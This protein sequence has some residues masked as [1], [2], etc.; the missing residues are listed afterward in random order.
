MSTRSTV[1]SGRPVRGD[2]IRASAVLAGAIV[3]IIIGGL[4]GS[5][6]FGLS[7]GQVAQDDPTPVMPASAAF[8]IWGLVYAAFL[9]VAVRQ[10]LPDQLARP[11]HRATGWWL[12]A[13]SVFNAGWILVFSSQLVLLSQFVIVALLVTPR[14]DSRPTLGPPGAGRGRPPAA[15]RGRSRSTPA[16]VSLA[17]VVGFATTG[18]SLGIDS[19][20]ALGV[21]LGT[22]DPAG[23][24]RD[25]RVGRR[26]RRGRRAVRRRGGVG[27]V[28]RRRG[29]SLR[30]RCSWPPLVTI[31]T[32]VVVA[33]RRIAAA[34]RRIRAAAA[35]G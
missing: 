2:R 8:S 24:R 4:G 21:V 9:A 16:G 25:R 17:T 18:A 3:Q 13:S 6:A 14:G 1:R 7:V 15:A 35:F 31:V 33:V 26:S 22:G 28:L 23:G 19:T 30:S 10:L 34:P 29:R 20:G 32:V 12:V 11:V 27:A 5:G